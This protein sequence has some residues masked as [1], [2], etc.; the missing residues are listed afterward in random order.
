M[1]Y[2]VF[3]RRVLQGSSG[4]GTEPTSIHVEQVI[5]SHAGLPGHASGNND[6]VSALKGTSQLVRASVRTDLQVCRKY[7]NV[8]SDDGLSR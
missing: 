1:R 5:T 4:L 3:I 8:R 6:K 7:C 2:I